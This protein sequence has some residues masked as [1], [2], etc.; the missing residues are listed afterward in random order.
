[1]SCGVGCR[2]GP[3]PALLWLWLRPAALAPIG[4]LAWEFP[5]AMSVALKSKEKKKKKENHVDLSVADDTMKFWN[6]N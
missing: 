2:R 1:M 5:H 3:D 6:Y 4:P